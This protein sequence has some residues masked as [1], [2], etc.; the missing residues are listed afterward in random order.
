MTVLISCELTGPEKEAQA[1]AVPAGE[2]IRRRGAWIG[3]IERKAVVGCMSR[4]TW[5]A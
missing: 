4:L 2:M 3:I 5:K 1:N